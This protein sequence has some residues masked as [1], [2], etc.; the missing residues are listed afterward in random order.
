MEGEI[1]PSPNNTCEDCTCTDGVI[2]C[3]KRSCPRLDCKV[4]ADPDLSKGEC[5]PYCLSKCFVVQL[6][7][8]VDFWQLLIVLFIVNCCL[9]E[10]VRWKERTTSTGR[11]RK[12]AV[13]IG[14]AT[15]AT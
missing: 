1:W 15:T 4:P 7:A 11:R 12:L 6:K 5:C 10:I 13:L 9:Q 3:Y 8:G 14:S 2:S